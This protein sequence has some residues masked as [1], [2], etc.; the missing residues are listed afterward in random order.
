MRG[1]AIPCARCRITRAPCSR[2][3]S[4]RPVPGGRRRARTRPRSWA[5]DAAVARAA[6]REAVPPLPSVDAAAD[7]RPMEVTA[8]VARV[9]QRAGLDPKTYEAAEDLARAVCDRVPESGPALTAH[10]GALYR[11][12]RYDEALEM[13]ANANDKKRGLPA[14]L[15]FRAMALA[16]LDRGDEARAMLARLATLLKEERWANDVEANALHEEA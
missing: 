13:L 15:A 16:E 8:I 3:R 7:M 6:Q 12:G 2:W 9:V 1:P 14:N 11:L 4:I 5:T 10:G